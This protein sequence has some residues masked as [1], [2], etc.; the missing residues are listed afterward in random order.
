MRIY[1]SKLQKREILGLPLHLNLLGGAWGSME[2]RKTDTHLTGKSTLSN[3]SLWN[4]GMLMRLCAGQNPK[5]MVMVLMSVCDSSED[6]GVIQ[7]G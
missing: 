5:A 3:T 7:R 1:Y 2:H 6:P 4:Y